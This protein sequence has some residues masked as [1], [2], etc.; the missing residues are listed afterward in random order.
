MPSD[1]DNNLPG[2]VVAQALATLQRLGVDIIQCTNEEADQRCLYLVQPPF[3]AY[4]IVSTDS[5]FFL[6]SGSRYNNLSGN[7]VSLFHI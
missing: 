2:V 7:V 3:N 6:M 5:D 4:A 1:L